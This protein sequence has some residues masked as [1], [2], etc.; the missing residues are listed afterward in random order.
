MNEKTRKIALEEINNQLI[1][2]TIS[3]V[4]DALLERGYNPIDQIVGYLLSG[5][6]GYI[7]SHKDARNKI[8]RFD[9]NQ[10]IEIILK[11][12]LENKKWDT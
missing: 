12:Y 4:Y 9:R 7:S 6:L 5:D 10:I 3:E 1:F 2:D 11:D 8:N